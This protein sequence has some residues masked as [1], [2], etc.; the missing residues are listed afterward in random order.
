MSA[1]SVPGAVLASEASE[2][3]KRAPTLKVFHLGHPIRVFPSFVL[4]SVIGSNFYF[5]GGE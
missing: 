1:Y 3:A 2:A 5:L 4:V